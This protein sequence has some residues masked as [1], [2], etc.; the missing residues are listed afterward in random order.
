MGPLQMDVAG[1]HRP[2]SLR[3][4]A[5][6]R[7]GDVVVSSKYQIKKPARSCRKVF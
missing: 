6:A 1:L 5:Y 7:R 3:M 2:A 4:L